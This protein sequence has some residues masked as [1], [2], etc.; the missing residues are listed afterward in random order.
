MLIGETKEKQLERKE[1][2]TSVDLFIELTSWIYRSENFNQLISFFISFD[3]IS[4]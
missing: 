1:F 3:Q 4:F 2:K